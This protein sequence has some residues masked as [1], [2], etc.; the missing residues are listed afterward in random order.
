M[1]L[2]LAAKAAAGLTAAVALTMAVGAATAPAAFAASAANPTPLPAVITTTAA[3]LNV[4][5]QV[6]DGW[7]AI[8]GQAAVV[9]YIRAIAV[10]LNVGNVVAYTGQYESGNAILIFT[11]NDSPT[12]AATA[13]QVSGNPTFLSVSNDTDQSWF[14]YNST[15]PGFASASLPSG[16]SQ[17]ITGGGNVLAPVLG[18]LSAFSPVTFTM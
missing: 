11:G 10:S 17:N 4:P 13:F 6:N 9:D 18:T 5:V 12:T 7:E 2:P 14:I 3:Q 16:V 15:S 8:T 1:K